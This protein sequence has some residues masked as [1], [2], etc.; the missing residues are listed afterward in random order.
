MNSWGN[1]SWAMFAWRSYRRPTSGSSSRSRARSSTCGAVE[2]VIDV[3]LGGMAGSTRP[4]CVDLHRSVPRLEADDPFA[5]P[6]A[7]VGARSGGH[8]RAVASLASPRAT[9]GRRLHASNQ[10]T[11]TAAVAATILVVGVVT[12]TLASPASGVTPTVLARGT[13][14]AFKVTHLSGRRGHG[15]GR[16]RRT[17]STSSSASTSTPRAR[18]PAGTGTLTRC[19]SPSSRR[20]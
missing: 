20:P 11:R 8:L 10:G 4:T 7:S 2:S 6:V 5:G 9:S 13:Y 14:D 15:Q 18:R 3:S 16:I 17:P 19:S 12:A 1:H